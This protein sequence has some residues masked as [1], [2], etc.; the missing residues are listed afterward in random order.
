MFEDRTMRLQAPALLAVAAVVWMGAGV[1]TRA[2]DEPGGRA[3]IRFTRYVVTGMGTLGGPNSEAWGINNAG[4]VVGRADL[5][6]DGGGNVYH[7]AVLHQAGMTTDLGTGQGCNPSSSY[8]WALDIN[9]AGQIVGRTCANNRYPR[10]FLRSGGVMIDLGTLGGTLSWARGINNAGDVVGTSATP[11]DA[12]SHAFLYRNNSMLDLGTPGTG[13]SE[14]LHINDHGSVVGYANYPNGTHAFLY[15][16]NAMIDLTPSAPCCNYA[17]GINDSDKVVGTAVGA[18]FGVGHDAGFLYSN[19]SMANL[20]ALANSVTV[21]MSINELD[22]IVGYS[23]LGYNYFHAFLYE[24]GT[25]VDLNHHIPDNPEW[26]LNFATAINDVGQI[27]GIGTTG[28]QTRGFLLTPVPTPPTAVDDAYA[29]GFG[30]PLTVSAPGVLANDYGSG[31]S[32][33]VAGQVTTPAHGTAVLNPDGGFVYTPAQGYSGPDAFTYR[34]INITGTSNLA[35]VSLTVGQPPN[36]QPPTKLYTHSV[37]GSVVTLRWVPPAAGPR[38][39]G[40]AIEGGVQ[41]DEVL[42]VLPTGSSSPIHAF[43]APSGS[44]YVRVRA[45]A[46]PDRSA[47]SNEIRVH[48]GVPAPPSAPAALASVVD[49]STVNL[50]WRNTFEGGA[51]TGVVLEARA[52][53]AVSYIPLGLID[54]FGA[55]GVPAGSYTLRVWAINAGGV[56]G[57]SNQIAVTVPGACSGPPGAPVSFLAYAL[58][59]TLFILWDMPTPGPAAT[60]YEVIASGAVSGRFALPTRAVSGTVGPGTYDLSVVASNTCGSGP[61]TPVQTVTVQ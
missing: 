30:A 43:V 1:P 20:G 31:L 17:W 3:G 16:N 42:A 6:P 53:P 33:M 25:M 36:V 44:F 35:T 22:Q 56:S 27:V 19:G 14:A 49:G 50:A 47:P 5:A 21:A 28:G 13:A 52:G 48:V 15:R 29:T 61:A 12:T 4:Q 37:A 34:A 57:P 55:A 39:T 32:S 2:D 38:P 8:S 59:R 40:Y 45:L 60:G 23:A 26:E 58:G 54:T 41:P 46:G 18:L 10:A 11:G 9:D 24:N 7:H 51:A